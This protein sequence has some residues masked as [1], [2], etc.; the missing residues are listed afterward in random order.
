VFELRHAVFPILPLRPEDEDT[1]RVYCAPN[2]QGSAFF[3]AKHGVFLTAKHVVKDWSADSYSVIAFHFGVKAHKACRVRQLERHP[4]VDIAVGLAEKPGSSGWPHPFT[5]GRSGLRDGDEILTYGYA[6]TTVS[7][8]RSPEGPFNLDDSLTL[9]MAPQPYSGRIVE[10]M[11]RGPL[12]DGPCYHVSCDPGG[13]ISGGP[14]IHTRT[15]R[16]H[17]IFTAGIPSHEA[18]AEETGFAIDLRAV[19]DEW[20]IPFLDGLTLRDY[21]RKYPARM[22]VF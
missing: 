14:L 16:V 21:A 2:D 6:R 20:P 7:P 4:D 13:G 17:G 5:L 18:G 8:Q 19:L 1:T 22:S 10:H 9:G 3:V 11:P 15:M 12:I